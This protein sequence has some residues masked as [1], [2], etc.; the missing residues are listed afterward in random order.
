MTY[1]PELGPGSR[2]AMRI[3]SKKALR[4]F[5]EGVPDSEQPLRAWHS[6]VKK[7]NWETP[8]DVLA[9]YN[10]ASILRNNRV[11]FRIK[12]NQYRLVVAIRYDLGIVYIRFVGTHAEYNQIYAETI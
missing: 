7:A 9:S 11:V 2:H 6:R 5:W 12:G 10:R 1:V 8:A 4:E 3:I